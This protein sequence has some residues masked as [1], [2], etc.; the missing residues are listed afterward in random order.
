MTKKIADAF[1]LQPDALEVIAD[2]EYPDKTGYCESC[3][4]W[5]KKYAELEAVLATRKEINRIMASGE[6]NLP[7]NQ[8][9]CV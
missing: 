9:F 8:D 4:A 1:G 3:D 2:H 7:E 5:A 6:C